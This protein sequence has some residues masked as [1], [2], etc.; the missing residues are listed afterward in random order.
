MV[1]RINAIAGSSSLFKRFMGLKFVQLFLAL[2]LATYMRLVRRTTRWQFEGLEIAK[3]LRDSGDGFV[4]CVWHS[5]FMLAPAGWSKM[6]QKPHMLISKSRDGNLVAYTAEFLGVKT[7]R[8]S[9]RAKLNHKNKRGAGA[10]R[11]MIEVINA[12]DCVVMTPDGPRGP[13]M[14]MGAGPLKLAKLS[15]AP[16]VAYALSASN[17]KLFNSWDR[18]MLPLPFGRGKIIFAGPIWVDKQADD[19]DIERVRQKL[20]NI[21]NQAS[22]KCDRDMGSEIIGPADNKTKNK[23]ANQKANKKAKP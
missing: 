22:Q 16:V 10:L 4:A 3:S 11:E 1:C 15:G 9:R 5:R 18:F 21:L 20:E 6:V 19:A 2:L 7:V 17:N 23:Q 13:R 14:R 8:G 12:G